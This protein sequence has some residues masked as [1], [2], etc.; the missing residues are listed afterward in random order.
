VRQI[1]AAALQKLRR[2]LE[3]RGI[4]WPGG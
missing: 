2:R 3:A 1:E 4:D